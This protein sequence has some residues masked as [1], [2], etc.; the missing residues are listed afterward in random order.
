VLA[1][2]WGVQLIAIWL[3]S[4]FPLLTL[5]ETLFNMHVVVG[6]VSSTMQAS[7]AL[8]PSADMH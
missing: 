5:H 7:Y 8:L 4:S 6:P 2:I 3:L 1:L